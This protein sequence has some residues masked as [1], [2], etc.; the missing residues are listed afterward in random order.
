MTPYT[1]TNAP[2]ILTM[3]FS[4][5]VAQHVTNVSLEP[6]EFKPLGA[7]VGLQQYVAIHRAHDMDKNCPTMVEGLT[8][9]IGSGPR[10]ADDF[11]ALLGVWHKSWDEELNRQIDYEIDEFFEEI[12][13]FI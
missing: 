1:T 9:S 6:I 5:T 4:P 12:K 3:G 7:T 11:E 10:F 8:V 13:A 2:T